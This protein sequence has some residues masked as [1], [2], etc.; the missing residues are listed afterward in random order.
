MIT[1]VFA[2][3]KGGVGKT[4]SAVSVAW[5][6]S[7]LDKGRVLLIDL[8]DQ[9]NA[10][11][12]AGG[13]REHDGITEFLLQRRSPATFR[14]D[15]TVEINPN[16]D[17]CP[18]S[19]SFGEHQDQLQQAKNYQNQLRGKLS[20]LVDQYEYVLIDCPPALNAM[21]Y[22]AFV[23]A[24]WFVVVAEPEPLAKQGIDR[25][26][27]IATALRQKDNPRLKCAGILF[28]R[29]NASER[30]RVRQEVVSVTYED[31]GDELRLPSIRRDIA[32]PESQAAGQP[33]PVYAPKSRATDDYQ[34]LTLV[35]LGRILGL[36]TTV[37]GI[38][39]NS[40]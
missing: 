34:Q 38:I 20:G 10:T 24:D 16:L 23:A 33:L 5:E 28:T 4:T 27:D 3:N 30:G 15:Y 14:Q 1:V 29:F 21:N 12:T 35:L 18:A 6:L 2:N 37:S 36:N 26:M 22:N 31:Y 25:I 39:Q 11:E 17:L 19:H 7:Q 40:L 13:S 9:G 8:D 32:I